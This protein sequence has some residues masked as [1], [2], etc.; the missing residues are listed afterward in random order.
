MKRVGCLAVLLMLALLPGL[1]LAQA[2]HPEGNILTDAQVEQLYKAVCREPP[3]PERYKLLSGETELGWKCDAARDYPN[4][5][6]DRCSIGLGGRD[7]EGRASI[8]YGQFS[9]RRPQA[10]VRYASG[11]ESFATNSG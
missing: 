1:A 4:K 8:F 10:F 2:Q 7:K 3:V 6:F 9:A 11:C 5:V